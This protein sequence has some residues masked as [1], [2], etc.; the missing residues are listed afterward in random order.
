[1]D[2][3]RLASPLFEFAIALFIGALV[4]IER[5]KKLE[6]QGERGIGGLRTFILFAQAGAVAAWLSQRLQ[7]PW[8][9]IGTGA[10]VTAIL[11]A[12]YLAYTRKREEFGL[13]TE[14]AALVVYLLGG[15]TLLGSPQLAVALGITTSAL[16]AYKEPLHATVERL[17]RDDLYAGLKLLIATFIVLPV[18]PDRTLDPWDALN[19]YKMWWLVILI[20]GLSLV[21]YA[22]T[23]A[24]GSGRGVAVT[25]LFGGLVS[26]TAVTLSLARRSREEAARPALASTLAAGILIAWAIMFLRVGAV[27][28][29]LDWGLFGRLAPPLLLSALLT[30]API[31]PTLRSLFRAASAEE[32]PLRNPFSL[33]SA[34]RFAAIFAVVLLLVKITQRYAPASGLYL[35]A[36]LAGLTD[37]D[38]ISLSMAT[39]ARGET[40]PPQVAGGAILI[41]LLSNT[42]VKL[43]LAWTL[44]A[45][46]LRRPLAL[47]TGLLLAASIAGL[48]WLR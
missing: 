29:A 39:G 24:L 44:G 20:S 15:T 35:V 45:P 14:V 19:P 22:A 1:M 6:T 10:L 41:A 30:L 37:V 28:G 36:A 42:L 47:A 48:W 12:G 23:R 21:G 32:V 33:T 26:S 34:I 11:V 3:L 2:E 46:G 7:T 25:A 16:L 9:F 27:V 43:G 31:A 18:L 5:E 17:G 40:I 13:T 4:G 38:A 8:I